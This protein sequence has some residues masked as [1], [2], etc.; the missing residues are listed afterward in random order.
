MEGQLRSK[1]NRIEL[2]LQM[3][4]DKPLVANEE[5]RREFVGQR[6]IL[7]R[8][9]HVTEKKNQAISGYCF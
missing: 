1:Q 4:N 3:Q 7:C 6:T 5:Q 8:H 9:I 2:A